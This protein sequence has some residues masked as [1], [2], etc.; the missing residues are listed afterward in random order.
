VTSPRGDRMRLSRGWACAATLALAA[1]APLRAQT[2]AE[3]QV[4]PQTMTL[5]IGQKQPIFAA[6]FDRKGNLIPN[7]RF[8]YWTSDS[9]VAQ[10]QVDGLVIGRKPGIAKVE[11]RAQGRRAS[12][13]VLVGEVDSAGT[14]GN[15]SGLTALT[16]DPVSLQLLPGEHAH[17]TPQAVRDDGTAVPTGRVSWKSL[18]PEVARVDSNGNVI[19]VAPGRTIIQAASAGVMATAPVQVDTAQVVLS[20]DRVVLAPDELDTLRLSVPTQANRVASAGAD[21]GDVAGASCSTTTR[22]TTRP[23]SLLSGYLTISR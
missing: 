23:A 1:T 16:L 20:K 13:A 11:A 4:S 3:V 12:L 17:L 7:A 8:T 9:A 15:H 10:V 2:I 18:R 21:R 22:S 14:V 5:K 6:A 19:G